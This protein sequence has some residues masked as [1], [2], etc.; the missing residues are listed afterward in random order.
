MNWKIVVVLAFLS[1]LITGGT[2][3]MTAFT[4]EGVS[5]FSDISPAQ[6]MTILI[7]FLVSLAREISLKLEEM[8]K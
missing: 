6:Y 3:A 4:A 7:G 2:A 1:A 5:T 8:K